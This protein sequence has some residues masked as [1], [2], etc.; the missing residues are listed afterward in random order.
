M[1]HGR[2]ECAGACPQGR[3]HASEEEGGSWEA[4]PAIGI[5]R[6][7]ATTTT[8]AGRGGAVLTSTMSNANVVPVSS[9]RRLPMCRVAKDARWRVCGPKRKVVV[10]DQE[11][12][13]GSRSGDPF[14]TGFFACN[15]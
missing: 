6:P 13:E 2:P 1:P 3:W 5:E 10:R 14:G 7:G 9:E 4:E 8:G 15:L 11:A 12:L